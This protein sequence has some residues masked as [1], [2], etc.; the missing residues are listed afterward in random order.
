MVAATAVLA[1]V[2]VAFSLSA[3]PLFDLS[4]RAALDLLDPARYIDAVL[5]ARR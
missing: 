5:G 1:A 4:E 3:G 2:S